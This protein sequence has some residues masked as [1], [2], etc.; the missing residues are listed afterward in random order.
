MVT[1]AFEFWK[2]ECSNIAHMMLSMVGIA[3]FYLVSQSVSGSSIDSFFFE[4]RKF[5]VDDLIRFIDTK[6]LIVLF[7]A[8]FNY[9][10]ERQ[11][12]FRW[13]IDRDLLQTVMMYIAWIN[14]LFG[15]GGLLR[16][17]W[18]IY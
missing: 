9:S 5:G 6:S 16:R 4:I 13:E 12:I 8:K 18:H 2:T 14:G 17:D 11:L 3:F 1:C 10:G 15:S 7:T